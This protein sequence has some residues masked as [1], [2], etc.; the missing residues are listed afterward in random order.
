MAHD[1]LTETRGGAT[2]VTFNRPLHN[3]ALNMDLANQLF[4]T[5]KLLTTDRTVRAV[6]LRGQGENFMDGLEMDIYNNP[7]FSKG[8]ERHNELM[9]PYHSAIREL[10]TMEKPVLAMVRGKVSGPGLS[11]MLA[12]DLVLASQNTEFNAGFLLRR[13]AGRRIIFFPDA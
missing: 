10:N 12:S 11:F 2:I 13:N 9:L 4:N 1:I 8:V 3:N 6:L 7:D 5:L